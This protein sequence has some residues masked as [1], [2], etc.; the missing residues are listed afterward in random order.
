ME[1]LLA[2]VLPDWHCGGVARTEDWL[3]CVRR[4]WGVDVSLQSADLVTAVGGSVW[5]RRWEAGG[6]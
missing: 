6:P 3:W 1:E 4:C 5:I 2:G